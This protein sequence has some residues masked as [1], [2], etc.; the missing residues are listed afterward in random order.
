[1]AKWSRSLGDCLHRRRPVVAYYAPV[2][3]EELGRIAF[4]ARMGSRP[5]PIFRLVFRS[6]TAARD[7]KAAL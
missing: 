3:R 4:P 7:G 6:G 5:N 2:I 1:M